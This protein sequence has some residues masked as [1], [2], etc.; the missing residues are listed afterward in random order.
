MSNF[1][2][3]NPEL[4]VERFDKKLGR[5]ITVDCPNIVSEYNKFMG[6]VDLL[7]SFI[8]RNKI[9]IRSKK[10]Y[11]RLF[12]HLVDTALVNAWLLYKRAELQKG[13]NVKDTLADFRLKVGE[14][15]CK[16][17]KTSIAR[18]RPSELTKNLIYYI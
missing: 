12:Y 5:K 3:K 16:M 7:D 14:T 17:G 6:G 1:C 2:G 15:L 10:W 4:S 8:G 11:M 18:G 9:K 13:N